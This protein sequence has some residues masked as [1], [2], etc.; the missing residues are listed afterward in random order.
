MCKLTH[1]SFSLDFCR[2]LAHAFVPHLYHIVHTS[3]L[4]NEEMCAI[5]INDDCVP[6][7]KPLPPHLNWT[8]PLP[9]PPPPR[10]APVQPQS[11]MLSLNDDDGTI[12]D[13]QQ[14]Q[15]QESLSSGGST[16]SSSSSSSRSFR[17]LHLSDA[18]FDAN[19]VEGFGVDC[20]EPLC[21]RPQSTNSRGSR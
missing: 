3:P 7:N 12:V 4:T 2:K 11:S 13:G 1:P 19:Y 16:S 15:Q 10:P 20:G 5:M 6:P 18:H 8:I 9:P 14:Q 21:C 17:I